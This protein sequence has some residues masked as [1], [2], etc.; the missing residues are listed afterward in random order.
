M[1]I[2]SWNVNG[3]RAVERKGALDE[4]L[5]MYDPDLLLFQETKASVEKLSKYLTEHVEYVQFYHAAQKPG[6]SGTSIWGRRS[7]FADAEYI[8]GMPQF[9][10]E[11]GRIAQIRFQNWSIFGVYFPNGGKS[12]QAW[13]EKLLFYRRFLE[14]TNSLRREGRKVLWAGDVN[15]AHSEIDIARPK[16]NKNSIGFLPEERS[17]VDSVLQAGWNDIFRTL[18][19]EKTIYS[20]WHVISRA[21]ER[22]IGWRI[23]YFFIDSVLMPL[24]YDVTYLTDQMGSDHCPVLLEVDI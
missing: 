8:P 19:P 16:E 12:P 13:E 17:W 24:V 3:I 5:R 15:C 23:D 18:H 7:L 21:R 6:Y 14:Y 22:N 11:E 2:I 10:D 9:A 20:W 1:K 4:L